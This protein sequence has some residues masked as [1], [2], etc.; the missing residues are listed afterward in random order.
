MVILWPAVNAAMDLALVK[1][2]LVNS[3]TLAVVR[4]TV[5]AFNATFVVVAYDASCALV[6]YTDS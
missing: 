3:V 2:K 1:Y 5:F 6:A 4:S